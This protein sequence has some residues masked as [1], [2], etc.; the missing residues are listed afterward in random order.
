M[1]IDELAR[2]TIFACQAE[3]VDYMVTGA[4]AV[5]Y[6]GYPQATKDIDLVISLEPKSGIPNLLERLKDFVEFQPRVQL[7]THTR[8]RRHI[9]ETRNGEVF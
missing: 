7:D 8:G 9:G 5:S 4:Y 3:G 1:T 6:Y 2:K